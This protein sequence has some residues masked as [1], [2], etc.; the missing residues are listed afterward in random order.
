M[1]SRT[2]VGSAGWS[3]IEFEWTEGLRS[4][5]TS[6]DMAVCS[7]LTA[8]FS[9]L[10]VVCPEEEL[11][12]KNYTFVFM[13]LLAFYISHCQVASVFFEFGSINSIIDGLLKYE[14]QLAFILKSEYSR[15]LC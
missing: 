8:E 14:K 11:V 7:S 1:H 3:P 12:L 4:L 9:E 2:S 5:R 10:F 15:A 6:R 13:A